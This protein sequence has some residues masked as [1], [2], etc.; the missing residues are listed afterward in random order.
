MSECIV[1]VDTAIFVLES[2][3]FL[4]QR[5]KG[6]TEMDLKSMTQQCFVC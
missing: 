3:E 6:Q 4:L 1:F 2:L 5:N